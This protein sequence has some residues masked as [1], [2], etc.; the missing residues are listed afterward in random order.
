M[1]ADPLDDLFQ[2]CALAAFLEQS[3][4]EQSWPDPE[5]TRRLAYRLYEQALAEKN[6]ERS[7]EARP[8]E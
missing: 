5:A 4:R 8:V 1:T 6:R 7:S 2:G 3:A